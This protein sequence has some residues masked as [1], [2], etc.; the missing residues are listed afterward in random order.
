VESL[1]QQVDGLVLSGLVF[2][3]GLI[4]AAYAHCIG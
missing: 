2:R 1:R 3:L 4:C